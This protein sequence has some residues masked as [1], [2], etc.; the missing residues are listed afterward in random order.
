MACRAFRAEGRRLEFC[1]LYHFLPEVASFS[2]LVGRLSDSVVRRV[3][4]WRSIGVTWKYDSLP[5][6][7]FGTVQVSVSPSTCRLPFS[8]SGNAI[9]HSDR[10]SPI[11]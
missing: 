10:A 6:N 9:K 2:S 8:D 3:A 4:L 5:A 1:G 7:C 11:D